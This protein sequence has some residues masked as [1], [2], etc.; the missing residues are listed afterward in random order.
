MEAD[1]P[2]AVEVSA[3]AVTAVAVEGAEEAVAAEVT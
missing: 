2:V 1:A 3:A